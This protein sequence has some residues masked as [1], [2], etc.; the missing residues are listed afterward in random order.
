MSSCDDG[1]EGSCR[2]IL[3]SNGLTSSALQSKFHELA[4]HAARV[5]YIPT[6]AL[7]DGWSEQEVR[8]QKTDIQQVTIKPKTH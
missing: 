7:H 2:A 4:P 8:E 6:A 1:C 5:W 3:T